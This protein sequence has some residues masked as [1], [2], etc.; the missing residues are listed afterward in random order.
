MHMF[1]MRG[2]VCYFDNVTII[3]IMEI[4]RKIVYVLSLV[5]VVAAVVVGEE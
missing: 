4:L 2:P 5:V 1:I 3:S